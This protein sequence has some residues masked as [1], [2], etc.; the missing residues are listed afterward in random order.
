MKEKLILLHGALGTKGQFN[1]LTKLLSDPFDVFSL[2]F[3]G[4]G[5]RPF[6]GEFSIDTFSKNLADFLDSNEIN[7]T[8]I[9]GY[10]MGGYIALHGAIQ[11]PERI[12]K[13]ITLGTKFKW[14][15]ES[16]AKEVKMLDPKKIEQKVPHFAEKLKADHHPNHWKTVVKNTANMM[17][18]MGNGHKLNLS[19][20][21]KITTPVTI[22]IGDQDKMVTIEESE[23]VAQHI[24]KSDFVILENVVHPIEKVKIDVLTSLIT[25]SLHR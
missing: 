2:N 24:P 21:Q 18:K 6:G 5:G 16:A 12:K 9:F 7:E 13:I 11:I 3:E 20:F 8:N 19:D 25:Q 4:H 22:A 10:S 15:E 17:I 23:E 14:T 1:E